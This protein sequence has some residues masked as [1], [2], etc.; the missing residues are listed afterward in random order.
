MGCESIGISRKQVVF[1]VK[2]TTCGTLKY[3]AAIDFIR[4][5]GLAIINQI[6]EFVP[7]EE[8]RNT[9]D[10]L[11][12]FQNQIPPGEWSVPMYARP[13]AT[14]GGTP[15]GDA[16]FQSWQGSLNATTPV[17]LARVCHHDINSASFAKTARY[18]G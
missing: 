18:A 12:E 14:L 9:L 8:L 16:L 17:C 5:A 3:P 2:E 15:Q 10:I 6:P 13:A 1:A 4:P 11:D 7:S